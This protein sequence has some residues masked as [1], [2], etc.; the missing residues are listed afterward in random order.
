MENASPHF[1]RLKY[2]VCFCFFFPTFDSFDGLFGFS[3][4]AVLF[5][6]IL[7]LILLFFFFKFSS[8]I[9]IINEFHYSTIKIISILFLTFSFLV[10]FS[11]I[12][13]LNNLVM[14]DVFELHRPLYYSLIVMSSMIISK[15]EHLLYRNFLFPFIII[16]IV[17][18]FL[19][20]IHPLKIPVFQN[21]FLFYTKTPNALGYRATGTFGNPYDFGVVMVFLSILSFQ[22]YL[23]KKKVYFLA[24]FLICLF[25]ML[26]SQSKTALFI[27]ISCFLYG[28]TISLIINRNLKI[29]SKFFLGII[30]TIFVGIFFYEDIYKLWIES[31]IYMDK[32]FDFERVIRKSF[33]TGNRLYDLFW[34]L[35]RYESANLLNWLFGLGIGKGIYDDIEFGYAIY[36]YRYGIIGLF[37]YISILL[38]TYMISLKSLMVSK[39]LKLDNYK[40]LFYAFHIWSFGIIIGTLANNF[41]DQPRITF[42][43]FSLVGLSLGFLISSYK[44]NYINKL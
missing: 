11:L 39:T 23:G 7:I 4:G 13:G 35:E 1:V 24:L 3:A 8:K 9:S 6:I 36:L 41:I 44:T 17:E 25:S 40:K 30:V 31:F 16:I 21:L 37:M 26:L 15:N 33:Q 12:A 14:R 32:A 34:V 38:G 2:L 42:L 27:F 29:I 22:I 43:Y 28:S 20:I 19:A 5:R 10:S 18:A